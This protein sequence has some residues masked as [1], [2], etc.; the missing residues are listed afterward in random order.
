MRREQEARIPL[1]R[2]A[3]PQEIAA[4]ALFLASDASSY[5][6]GACLPVEGGATLG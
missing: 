1:K 6:T 4:V 5:L 2:Y 3:E